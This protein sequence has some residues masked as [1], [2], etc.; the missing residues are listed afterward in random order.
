MNPPGVCTV[1]PAMEHPAILSARSSR[2]NR[3]AVLAVLAAVGVAA[4]ACTSAAATGKTAGAAANSPTVGV[5]HSSKGAVLVNAAGRTLYAFSA[6]TPQMIVCGSTCTPIWPVESVAAGTTP[7]AGPGV[8]GTL[9]TVTRSDG[10]HQVTYNG[11]LL[12]TY[13]GDSGPDQLNGQ[14]IVEQYGATKGTWSAVTPTSTSAAAAG[15]AA[16]AAPAPANPA[17]AA[18]TTTAPRP[19]AP[20]PTTTAPAAPATTAPPPAPTTTVP[21][22]TTTTSG[23]AWA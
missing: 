4:A 3:G 10:T 21:P 19:A 7:T 11:L 2:T 15:A 16:P 1:S 13:A 18:P 8:T 23:G 17:P 20:A 12:Y 9:G 14:G 6:D 5:G 22:T